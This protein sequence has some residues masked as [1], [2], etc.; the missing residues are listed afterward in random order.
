LATLLALAAAACSGHTT[1]VVSSGI[2]SAWANAPG[3]VK[4]ASSS[5]RMGSA[6]AWTPYFHMDGGKLRVVGRLLTPGNSGVQWDVAVVP[7]KPR[8]LADGCGIKMLDTE[9]DPAM[10]NE[11]YFVGISQ[12][13]LAAGDYRVD[14]E[15]SP[16][17][18]SITVYVQ[19]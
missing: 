1:A 19:K 16:G 12:R 4:V 9:N 3:W 18:Y 11:M 8:S 2:P 6:W 10:R 14:I 7:H 15:G 17:S 5:G 13:S